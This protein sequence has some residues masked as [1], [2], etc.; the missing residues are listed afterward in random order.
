M[1]KCRIVFFL[2]LTAAFTNLVLAQGDRN[3]PKV[4]SPF[5][6]IGL[7]DFLDQ[8]FVA[9]SSMGG[10]GATFHDP[11]HI[12]VVN[13]ASFS[14]LKSTAFEIGLNASYTL[15]QSSK[16]TFDNWSGNLGYL[17]L[18]F[19]L[20][21]PINQVLDRRKP[22]KYDWGMGFTLSPYTVV[23]Y[24]LQINTSIP[25]TG[26][27]LYRYIGK[28]GTYKL[29]WSNAVKY[30]DFA[31]GL[32]LGYLFGKFSNEQII[33][34][35]DL[36]AARYD[37]Y[38]TTDVSVGGFIWNA[39]ATYDYVFK[40]PNDAKEMVPTGKR[41]VFGLSGNFTTNYDVTSTQL[42]ERIN[43]AYV[44]TN[45][46]NA[47]VF[48]VDTIVSPKVAQQGKG[49]LPATIHAGATYI[50]DNKYKIGI[51]ATYASWKNTRNDFSA[52]VFDNSWRIAVGGEFVP[53]ISSYNNYLKRIRYRYGVFYNTDPRTLNGY[54][55]TRAGVTSG[56]GFPIILPRQ[57]TSFVN[58]GFEVGQNGI[59]NSLQQTYYKINLGFTLNDNGWFYKRRYQ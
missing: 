51:Q 13:P 18:G 35:G 50:K 23:G 33:S 16:T 11:Y 19:P 55:M 15:T 2:L 57:Q 10:L 58:V 45:S 46:S 8:E 6:R 38:F 40:K 4:N 52:D 44:T 34:F 7:G 30:E 56:F 24:N 22:S 25:G 12:N 54:Q 42:K 17:S 27:H 28:G 41:I 49:S 5:S 48:S 39:G 36:G 3:T 59:E 29:N 31:F 26:E 9:S 21:N 20:K 47:S 43:Y 53:N 1:S 14:S 32:N 37:D